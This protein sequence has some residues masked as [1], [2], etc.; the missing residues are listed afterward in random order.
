MRK[1]VPNTVEPWNLDRKEVL[2][3]EGLGTDASQGMIQGNQSG[4]RMP[5]PVMFLVH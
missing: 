4:A 2:K 3:F 1:P 5:P